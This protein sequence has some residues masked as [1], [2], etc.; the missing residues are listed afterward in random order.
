VLIHLVMLGKIFFWGWNE[1][2]ITCKIQNRSWILR[3]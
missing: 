2:F 3:T 1:S